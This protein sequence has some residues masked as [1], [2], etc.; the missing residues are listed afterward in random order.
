MKTKAFLLLC[1]LSLASC[2]TPVLPGISHA[3]SSEA[4]SSK[5]FSS[6]SEASS[7]SQ[8]EE[9]SKEKEGSSAKESQ[10]SKKEETTASSGKETISS[11]TKPAV[12]SSK[13]EAS[14]SSSF[15]I[16]DT[17]SVCSVEAI[18]L[19]IGTYSSG[20]Y[21]KATI[22]DYQ[23]EHYR[24][25]KKDASCRLMPRPNE[26]LASSA[27]YN[28]TAFGNIY[29]VSFYYACQGY[30]S[31]SFRYGN[32]AFLKNEVTLDPAISFRSCMIPCGGASYFR[33]ETKESPLDISK[34]YVFYEKDSASSLPQSEITPSSKRI[35]PKVYEGTPVNGSTINVPVQVQYGENNEYT[36][37]K[38]KTYTYY[39]YDYVLEHPEV[40]GDA[41]QTDPADV[42]NY[43]IAFGAAPA[44]YVSENSHEARNLFGS[45]L[46]KK[47]QFY[48]G[49]KGYASSVPSRGYNPAY[50]ELD[51]A[52][53]GMDYSLAN[54][55]VGRV[56]VWE[57][58]FTCYEN[59][60]QAVFTDDHYATFRDYLNDGTFGERF[61][62]ERRY[63]P[64]IFTPA[65]TYLPAA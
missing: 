52:L 57:N 8:K 6:P 37:K 16:P 35:A 50:I 18:S 39:D 4:I 33:F 42:A 34:I 22:G 27:L 25:T 2:A 5:E 49:K 15:V 55:E 43:Y 12:S 38:Q 23:F 20:N 14:S 28:V 54:R 3:P 21:G 47:S 53:P 9:S 41:I 13:E 24:A 58:G 30:G 65:I 11:E 44:N 61:S 40:K 64:Y 32:D 51:I 29:A 62:A 60:R 45:A 48:Y 63:S 26:D 10:S 59:E 36:V 31:A 7:S 46:R 17:A 19:G 56:I 1:L